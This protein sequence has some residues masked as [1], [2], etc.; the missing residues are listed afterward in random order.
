[1]ACAG[2]DGAGGDGCVAVPG[3]GETDVA[4]VGA[5]TVDGRALDASG[6]AGGS[7]RAAGDPGGLSIEEGVACWAAAIPFKQIKATD[8][9]PNRVRR[10]TQTRIPNL[11]HAFNGLSKDT[12]M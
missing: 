9:V 8:V 6:A 11:Q 10:A 12:N 2:D 1:M 5:G 4:E 3:E 7:D